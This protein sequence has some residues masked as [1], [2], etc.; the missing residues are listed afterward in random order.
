M[1][2]ICE[3]AENKPIPSR[4]KPVQSLQNNARAKLICLCSNVISQTL[5]QVFAQ[6]EI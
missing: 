6:W 1:S 2:L 4:Q 3:Q 5:K